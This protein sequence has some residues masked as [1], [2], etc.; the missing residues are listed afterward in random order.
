VTARLT[1]REWLLGQRE[2]T[3]QLRLR[4]FELEL[5]RLVDRLP[6]PPGSSI[7]SLGWP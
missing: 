4:A 1:A 2:R 3:A 5:H 6:S 7:W